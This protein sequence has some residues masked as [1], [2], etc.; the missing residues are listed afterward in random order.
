MQLKYILKTIIILISL[1]SSS[2][3]ALEFRSISPIS[4]ASFTN[5]RENITLKN[6]CHPIG[7]EE[8]FPAETVIPIKKNKVKKLMRKLARSWNSSDL[9]SY[10]SN[11]FIDKNRLL[12]TIRESVPRDG[13]LR[14]LSVRGVEILKQ[15]I[16]PASEDTEG[17]R[18]SLVNAKVKTQ[19]EYNDANQGRVKSKADTQEYLLF[20]REKLAQ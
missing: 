1:Y 5:Q 10:L 18:F 6:L 3:K 4:S 9:A 12:D 11:E 17:Y 16:K 20:I 15:F 7:C 2:G 13:K 8:L 19:V 14:I